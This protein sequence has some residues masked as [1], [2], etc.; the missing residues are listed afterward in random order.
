MSAVAAVRD[1]PL[2]SVAHTMSCA[3]SS[4]LA[5]TTINTFPPTAGDCSTSRGVWRC[6]PSW[7]PH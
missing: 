1:Q 4:A 3:T 5:P 6:W 7:K 2:G